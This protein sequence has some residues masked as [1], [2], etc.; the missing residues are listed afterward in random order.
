MCWYK[1]DAQGR[2]I[3]S[4]AGTA[5]PPDVADDP[6][7]SSPREGEEERYGPYTP[8]GGTILDQYYWVLR[9]CPRPPTGEGGGD[10][11]TKPLEPAT[12]YYGSGDQ[13]FFW[14][15]RNPEEG[16][17][18]KQTF[19]QRTPSGREV[20]LTESGG[21]GDRIF[22]EKKCSC[23]IQEATHPCL[24]DPKKTCYWKCTEKRFSITLATGSDQALAEAKAYN[25][26]QTP[27][28]ECGKPAVTTEVPEDITGDPPGGEPGGTM[29]SFQ[30][31]DT[32]QYTCA[33]GGDGT[34]IKIDTI[35]RDRTKITYEQCPCKK[36]VPGCNAP[37]GECREHCLD[38]DTGVK[39]D[40]PP[41]VDCSAE[42]VKLQDNN[43]LE[44]NKV[45]WEKYKRE[46]LYQ[47][48]TS[49]FNSADFSAADSAFLQ[50]SSD[51]TLTEQ[52][53]ALLTSALDTALQTASDNQ[54]TIS[55]VAI[56]TGSIFDIWTATDSASDAASGTGFARS[57]GKAYSTSPLSFLHILATIAI[58]G[59]LILVFVEYKR[60]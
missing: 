3:G 1:V 27:E 34:K 35:P 50:Y 24:K 57:T 45:A 19:Q 42:E 14:R 10:P 59:V 55:D 48:S 30:D 54:L 2:D 43:K 6:G 44:Q 53:T 9:P 18:I 7:S 17:L 15:C 4:Y 39:C 40:G 23:E 49:G 12:I 8:V 58:L 46:I 5:V 21:S 13:T 51:G 11:P 22:K 56:G 38:T 31:T 28:K 20:W 37:S 25:I 47:L 41:L 33:I 52:E 32:S 60:K 16:E 26:C 29:T 36:N